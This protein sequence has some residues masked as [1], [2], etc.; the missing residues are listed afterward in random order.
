M[1]H[2]AIDAGVTLIDTADVYTSEVV[3]A[4]KFGLPW[5]ITLG[6]REGP[7][8]GQAGRR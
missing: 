7:R 5:V 4:T 1:V 8:D 2:R 3:L 6:R